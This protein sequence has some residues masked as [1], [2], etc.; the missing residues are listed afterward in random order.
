[1]GARKQTR[2]VTLDDEFEF[3]DGKEM[4]IRLITYMISY[5]FKHL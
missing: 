1:M 3:T 4:S 2:E 5:I